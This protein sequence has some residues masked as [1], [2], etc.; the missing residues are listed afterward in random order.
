M[1]LLFYHLQHKFVLQDKG[2]GFCVCNIDIL[3]LVSTH[4]ESAIFTLYISSEVWG[5]LL[6]LEFWIVWWFHLHLDVQSLPIT[7]KSCKIDSHP[8]KGVLDAIWYDKVCRW[9][10]AGLWIFSSA[11][12][13]STNTADY[14]DINCCR[15]TVKT[16]IFVSTSQEKNIKWYCWNL[17]LL[18]YDCLF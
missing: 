5:K 15:N 11:L 17:A 7:F 2:I 3:L 1:D 13:A 9:R 4:F 6:W 12:V 8:W 14:H 16:L 10:A 18:F